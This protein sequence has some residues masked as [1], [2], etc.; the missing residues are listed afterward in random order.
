MLAVLITPVLGRVALTWHS[1]VARYA[2][3]ERG[4]G[5]YV[6]QTGLTQAAAATLMSLFLVT[7]ILL[8]WG[9][10][11]VPGAPGGPH[12]PS[13]ADP[14]GGAVCRLP[15]AAVGRHHRRHHRRQY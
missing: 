1:A 3:E 11:P 15:Q 9:V 8:F 10:Q 4:I 7:S 14:P 12:S 6:N 5:D 2:R 13:A